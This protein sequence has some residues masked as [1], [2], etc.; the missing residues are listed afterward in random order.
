MTT[1]AI[2]PARRATRLGRI[3]DYLGEMFPPHLF[4]PYGIATFCSIYFATQALAGVGPL[5]LTGRAI[6]GA[7]SVVLFTLLLR[8]YD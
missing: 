3:F 7:L 2:S 5:R 6:A 4:V 8:V 1:L